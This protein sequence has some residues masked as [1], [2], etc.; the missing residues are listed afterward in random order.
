MA[1]MAR[2]SRSLIEG[3][4]DPGCNRH[5]G[6]SRSAAA[7]SANCSSC[8]IGV[9]FDTPDPEGTRPTAAAAAGSVTWW[10][11]L[12]EHLGTLPLAAVVAVAERLSAELMADDD[13]RAIADALPTGSFSYLGHARS[14]S[15][16]SARPSASALL[17]LDYSGSPLSPL[18]PLGNRRSTKT[19]DLHSG[20]VSPLLP[21]PAAGLAPLPPAGDQPLAHARSPARDRSPALDGSLHVGFA[22][23][24]SD[25]HNVSSLSAGALSVTNEPLPNHDV[26]NA[27]DDS[28]GICEVM[29]NV[30]VVDPLERTDMLMSRSAILQTDEEGNETVNGYTLWQ[31]LGR[32]AAGVCFLAFDEVENETRAIKVVPRATIDMSEVAIM[33]KLNHKHIVKIYECIDD[34]DADAVYLVMQYISDGPIAKLN[35]DGKCA[36]MSLTTVTPFCAQL[37]SAL[38]YLHRKGVMHGDIKPDNILVDSSGPQRTAFFTDFGVSRAFKR[39]GESIDPTDILGDSVLDSNYFESLNASPSSRGGDGLPR[40]NSFG[41]FAPAPSYPVGGADAAPTSASGSPEKLIRE[42]EQPVP[43]NRRM[44]VRNRS[45]SIVVAAENVVASRTTR[46]SGTSDVGLGFASFR[47]GFNSFR[48]QKVKVKGTN[49]GLGTPAFLSPEV[50]EGD[51]PT[52]AADMWA[53]GVTLFVMIYGMLPFNGTSYFDVKCCVVNDELQFPP[54]APQ[55]LKWQGLLRQLMHK[56]PKVRMTAPQLM[57]S[58][59]LQPF[60][61]QRSPSVSPSVSPSPPLSG[62]PQARAPKR[63]VSSVTEEMFGIV[64]DQERDAAVTKSGARVKRQ[65]VV[66]LLP[67]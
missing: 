52:I 53:F 38:F 47:T 21:G 61:P 51:P 3:I 58:P 4:I 28:P 59:L 29:E 27:N 23:I 49:Q 32:G 20:R 37:S 15:L 22:G 25:D 67:T 46:S 43:G 41:N 24:S 30:D 63:A 45:V 44:S 55:T 18:T 2:A 1:Q 26:P 6:A 39:S 12:R 13:R 5:G 8:N 42:V 57:S 9:G 11:H 64:T 16:H 56:N 60:M 10:R 31:E 34:P 54:A 48:T 36:P 65:S 50:F 35:D 17:A 33:K 19:F 40:G 14:P 66:T 7:E 62:R